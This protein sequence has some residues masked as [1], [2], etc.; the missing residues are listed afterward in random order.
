[1][2]F[3]L[4]LPQHKSFEEDR[5]T[6]KTVTGG[7]D[8]GNIT[9]SICVGSFNVKVPFVCFMQINSH[10]P[11]R[12]A[13]RCCCCLTCIGVCKRALSRCSRNFQKMHLLFHLCDINLMLPS[14]FYPRGFDFMTIPS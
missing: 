7:K 4:S 12:L 11:T 13:L 14:Y 8:G 3:F 6:E 2:L 5:R 1:M 9:P 10:V